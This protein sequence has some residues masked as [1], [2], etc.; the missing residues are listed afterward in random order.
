M[1]SLH[2]TYQT[3]SNPENLH[4]LSY[5]DK[6]TRAGIGS[7]AP[8]STFAIDARQRQKELAL[9][10]FVKGMS[11]LLTCVRLGEQPD[12]PDGLARRKR[13]IAVP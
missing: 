11:E 6:V 3:A 5:R 4:F 7:S 2:Y 8:F 13:H 10:C 9:K 12:L 1:V